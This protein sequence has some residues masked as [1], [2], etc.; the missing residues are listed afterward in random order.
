MKKLYTY[1]P[2]FNDNDELLWV[3]FEEATAQV[4]SEFFFEDDASAACEFFE[5]GGAFAGF[6]PSFVLKKTQFGNI[7]DAFDVEFSE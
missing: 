4:I 5:R 3:V 6:T 1:Y 7:N 2:E